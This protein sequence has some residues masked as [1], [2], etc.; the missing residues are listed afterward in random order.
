MPKLIDTDALFRATIDV[1]AERGYEALTTREVARRAG[2]NEVTIYRRF[3]TKAALVAAALAHG[4]SASPFADL[5]LGDDVESDL[6]RMAEAF[7]ATSR[8]FG[9]AV[10]TLLN[11]A[12]RHPEL[13]AAMAPLLANMGRA[14]R[15]LQMHQRQGRLAPTDPWQQLVLLLSPFLASG[16]W[17]R[18]GATPPADLDTVSVVTAFLDGHRARCPSP[19]RSRL[20]PNAPAPD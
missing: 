4:L 1:F 12:S 16:L 7:R 6:L 17:A 3:G 20:G 11:E 10:I 18:T 14:V 15:I 13:G 19:H 9:G 8:T 2:I 5:T